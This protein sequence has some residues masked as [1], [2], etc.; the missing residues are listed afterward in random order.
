MITLPDI[1]DLIGKSY[2][3]GGRGPSEYDCAGVVLEVLR[4]AGF[5]PRDFVDDPKAAETEWVEESF[6]SPLSVLQVASSGRIA[7]HLAVYIGG[8]LIV[9]VTEEGVAVIP[10]SALPSPISVVRYV[11]K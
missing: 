1:Q 8:G 11:G 2:E 10:A 7:D 6:M 5:S 9:H 3:A 4:R